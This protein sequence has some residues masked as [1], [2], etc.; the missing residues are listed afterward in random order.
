MKRIFKQLSASE[1]NAI[2]QLC[3]VWAVALAMW[4]VWFVCC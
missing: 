1:K 3:G 4:C 2:M